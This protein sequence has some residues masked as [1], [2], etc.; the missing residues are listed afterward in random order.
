MVILLTNGTPSFAAPNRQGVI[1][2]VHVTDVRDVYFVVSWT[3]DSVSTGA[4][5]YGPAFAHL[6]ALIDG[7][8]CAQSGHDNHPLCRSVSPGREYHLLF[9]CR[10]WQ[11]DGRQWRGALFGHNGR[12]AGQCPSKSSNCRRCVCPGRLTRC[13]RGHCLLADSKRHWHLAASLGSHGQQRTLD[14]QSGKYPHGRTT[15]TISSGLRA[16]QSRSRRKAGIAG[17][18]QL[19]ASVPLGAASVGIHYFEWH[20]HRRHSGLVHRH[21]GRRI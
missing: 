4:V 17:T 11:H 10:R 3:T 2:P 9:R 7:Q 19:I 20:P 21:T 15:V 8:R 12:R 13:R 1:H 16:I 18:G 6:H 14:V 5:T